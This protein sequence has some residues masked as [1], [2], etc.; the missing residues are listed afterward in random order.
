MVELQDVSTDWELLGLYLGLAEAELNKVKQNKVEIR[1]YKMLAAWL[2]STPE[3]SW[4]DVVSALKI[5]K[6][7]CVAESIE[8]KYCVGVVTHTEGII[9]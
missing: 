5:V 2:S 1:K 4:E 8:K 6:Q 9:C 7:N 3:A